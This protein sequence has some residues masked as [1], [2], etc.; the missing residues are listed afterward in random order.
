MKQPL[1]DEERR[2]LTDPAA[3]G[4]KPLQLT[5]RLV[6]DI[7]IPA[8]A[9]ER[10]ALRDV[11]FEGVE[12]KG[13]RFSTARLERV[14]F[15]RC[16]MDGVSFEKSALSEWSMEDTILRDVRFQGCQLQRGRTTRVE[17]EKLT[18]DDC[19]VGQLEDDHG[20]YRGLS[21]RRV[22]VVAPAWKRTRIEGGRIEDT[23][24]EGG[25]LEGVSLTETPVHGLGL[26][27]IELRNVDFLYGEV[28]GLDVEA[29]RG[30]PLGFLELKCRG[31][32]VKA[33]DFSILS[34]GSV[35]LVGAVVEDCHDLRL[36]TLAHSQV[37]G[38]RVVRCGLQG[39]SFRES[40]VFGKSELE[41]CIIAGLD[42]EGTRVEGLAL[43]RSTIDGPVTA[44]KAAFSGLELEEVRYGPGYRLLDQGATY[45][46]GSRFPAKP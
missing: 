22:K 35:E 27:G 32:H 2:A 42:L 9:L 3:L 29:A 23:T 16:A 41:A 6:A 31:L 20:E 25:K 28:S 45:E 4:G 46:K 30:G 18:L 26:R 1:T 14:S 33:S 12:L 24:V 19:V 36:F 5:D 15:V 7:E 34:L 43:R 38:L 10:A 21:F 13:T 44:P 37:E 40:R 11:D 17:S 39:T 8:L